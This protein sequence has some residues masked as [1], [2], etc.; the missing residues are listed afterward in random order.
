MKVNFKGDT[1]V[2]ESFTKLFHGFIWRINEAHDYRL[3]LFTIG[4][5]EYYVRKRQQLENM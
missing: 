2:R 3:D 1:Q 4:G 5:N